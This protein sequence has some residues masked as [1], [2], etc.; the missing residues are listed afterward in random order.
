MAT[1][2]KRNGNGLT[3]MAKRVAPLATLIVI[4]GG[5]FGWLYTEVAFS[6]DV[7]AAIAEVK[8]DTKQVILDARR[9][10]LD[11]RIFEL[12]QKPKVERTDSDEALIDRYE[13][14]IRQIDLEL[15]E[16]SKRKAAK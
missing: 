12:K 13:R 2:R 11:D 8:D 3:E 16:I 4:I 1:R 14:Q 6:G 9:N 10:A 7:K 15:I 5:G